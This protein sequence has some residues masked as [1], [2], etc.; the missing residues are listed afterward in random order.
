MR[1]G[2]VKNSSTMRSNTI[3][4]LRSNTKKTT[5]PVYDYPR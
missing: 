2:S 4:V 3:K 1:A 5:L